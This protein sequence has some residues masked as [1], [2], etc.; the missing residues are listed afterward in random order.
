MLKAWME[1]LQEMSDGHFKIFSLFVVSLDSRSA[2]TNILKLY[3]SSPLKHFLI[4]ES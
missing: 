3:S 4:L 1:H 2:H